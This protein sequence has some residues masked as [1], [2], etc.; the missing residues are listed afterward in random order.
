MRRES[1]LPCFGIVWPAERLNE[2]PV[3]DVGVTREVLVAERSR[4]GG[5]RSATM[6]PLRLGRSKRNYLLLGLLPALWVCDLLLHLRT[7]GLLPQSF[8]RSDLVAVDL[9]VVILVIITGRIVP[10][11]TR[12]ALNDHSIGP[13]PSLN[14][15]AIIATISVV[16]VEFVA[17]TGVLMAI[18]S[19]LAGL[20]VMARS[21]RWGSFKT[22]GRP[23]LWI[24]HVG[25]AWIW[26]GLILKAISAVSLVVQPSIATHALTAG[27][28]GT[29][30]LGMMARV[31]LG[32]TGRPLVVSPLITVAFV[33]ISAS[34][35]LRVAGPWMRM[36]LTK[37][38]L[39]ASATLWL[40]AFA[41]YL[42]VNTRTLMTPR[43]DGKPG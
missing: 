42:L 38:I 12:N 21:L 32:H 28:I 37:P 30:T 1:V 18:V 7:S 43:P 2:R 41:L 20:L 39:I 14:L 23:V 29:L 22:L 6:F 4:V 13:V 25:H 17:P 3:F 15:A 33:A 24:L 34:A 26:I 35:V 40:L 36:D 9:I 27:A 8:L 11:F 10:L 16:L 19:G 31:T 5:A